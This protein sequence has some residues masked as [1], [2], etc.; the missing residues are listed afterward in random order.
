MVY[1][2]Y[3]SKNQI[4]ASN[5]FAA[6]SFTC[7]PKSTQIEIISQI[8]WWQ[9][10]IRKKLMDGFDTDG[11]VG[12]SRMKPPWIRSNKISIKKAK[13]EQTF[14]ETIPG[15]WMIPKSKKKAT[16]SRHLSLSFPNLNINIHRQSSTENRDNVFIE[17]RCR[18]SASSPSSYIL[19]IFTSG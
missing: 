15:Q 7:C 5:W 14:M 4:R 9:Q 18:E 10:N 17:M 19:S 8:Q 1:L 16:I 3:Q 11:P 6:N 12:V 2:N 13:T